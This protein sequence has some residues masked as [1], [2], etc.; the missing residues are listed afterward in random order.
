MRV[1]Q[2]VTAPVLACRPSFLIKPVQPIIDINKTA[3]ISLSMF[4]FINYYDAL[5]RLHRQIFGHI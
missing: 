2:P 5:L 1:E 4:I 3:M